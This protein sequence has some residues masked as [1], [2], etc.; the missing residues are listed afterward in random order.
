MTAA[1]KEPYA[2]WVEGMN[3]PTGL[4]VGAARGNVKL[5][6]IFLIELRLQLFDCL[7]FSSHT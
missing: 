4:I 7:S 2:G 6:K 5:L 1:W 3:G